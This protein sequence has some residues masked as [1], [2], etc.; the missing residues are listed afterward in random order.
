MNSCFTLVGFSANPSGE[1]ESMY[2]FKTAI[3]TPGKL[4]DY[5]YMGVVS[6]IHEIAN[7][8]GFYSGICALTYCRA[9]L[10]GC[11]TLIRTLGGGHLRIIRCDGLYHA[12]VHS[13]SMN[14]ANLEETHRQRPIRTSDATA[15]FSAL[16]DLKSSMDLSHGLL[17]SRKQGL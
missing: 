12:L 4:T 8:D 9:P 17:W 15:N 6:E 1:D 2:E 5:I 14:V 13:T 7:S 11:R 10:R 3:A 16:Q